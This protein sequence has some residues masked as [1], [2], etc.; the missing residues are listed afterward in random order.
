[1]IKKQGKDRKKIARGILVKEGGITYKLYTKP[2]YDKFGKVRL[3][4]YNISAYHKQNLPVSETSFLES[5]HGI[6]TDMTVAWVQ[7]KEYG[8]KL[9]EI[10]NNF[11][12]GKYKKKPY[13]PVKKI[14]SADVSS[15]IVMRKLIDLGKFPVGMKNPL[16][17]KYSAV[18]PKTFE[19]VFMPYQGCY[20]HGDID[21]MRKRDKF[22]Q[23]G[24]K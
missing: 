9:M 23:R 10:T 2:R 18:S 1:M 4:I 11:F 8:S 13:F 6:R 12:L 17:E 15:P 24:K 22:R 14:I 20:F 21:F 7:G 3:V 5:K 16:S 19:R